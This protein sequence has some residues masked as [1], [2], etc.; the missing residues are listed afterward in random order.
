MQT[1][2]NLTHISRTKG[3]DVQ[4]AGYGGY[5]GGNFDNYELVTIKLGRISND[6]QFLSLAQPQENEDW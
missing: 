6:L 2:K 4:N 1:S 3:S 5:R